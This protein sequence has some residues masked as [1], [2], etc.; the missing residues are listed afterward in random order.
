MLFR[1]RDEF[2]QSYDGYALLYIFYQYVLD[3]MVFC[4]VN[5][6]WK[7]YFQYELPKIANLFAA[8]HNNVTIERVPLDKTLCLQYFNKITVTLLR[9]L[10]QV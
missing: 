3:R 7:A 2:T 6:V 10:L 8:S 1:L 4:L 9:M 5:I